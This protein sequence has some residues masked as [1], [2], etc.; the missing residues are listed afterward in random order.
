MVLLVRSKRYNTWS[1]LKG[2]GIRAV[3]MAEGTVEGISLGDEEGM[4]EGTAEGVK[5]EMKM[6]WQRVPR[7]VHLRA[8][9]KERWKAQQ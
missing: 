8:F 7:M 2:G 4:H 5:L 6:A 1:T 3:G 9:E